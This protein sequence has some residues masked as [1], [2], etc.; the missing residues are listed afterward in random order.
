METQAQTCQGVWAER[1]AAVGWPQGQTVDMLHR[2]HSVVCFLLSYQSNRSVFV[3]LLMKS[4]HDFEVL[5]F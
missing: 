2:F 1:R 3:Q 4:L 5:S